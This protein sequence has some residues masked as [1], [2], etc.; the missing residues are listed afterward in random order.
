[1]ADGGGIQ[2][3]QCPQKEHLRGDKHPPPTTTQEP[4][5]RTTQERSKRNC[6][7]LSTYRSTDGD[8]AAK[9]RQPAP[10]ECDMAHGTVSQAKAS[11]AAKRDGAASAPKG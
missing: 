10:A 6:T 5:P 7:P 9:R 4:A 11:P 8:M 3:R 2:N 1:M